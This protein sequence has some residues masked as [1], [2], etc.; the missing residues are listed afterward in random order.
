MAELIGAICLYQA[1]GQAAG[2]AWSSW[3]GDMVP[4]ATRGTWFSRR[5]R[6]VY[7]AT[8]VGL[9]TGGLL[10][11][12]LAP[13]GTGAAGSAG[14]FALLL[15]IAAVARAVSGL[16]L[17]AAP[18]PNFSGLL[19]RRRAW[20]AAGTRRG[21]TA[22]R[23]LGLAAVFHFTVYW[24]SPYFSPFMLTDLGFTYLQYMA[25]ALSV[26]VVKAVVGPTWGLAADRSGPRRV[27]L[28]SMFVIAIVPL[29]WV[30]AHGIPLVVLGQVLSGAA[31]SGFEVGY[32]T[33]IL[34]NSRSRERPYLFALQSLGNGWMQLS[35]VMV[36]SLVILPLVGGYREVFAV[37]AVGRMLV[38]L[39]APFVLAGLVSGRRALREAV[40]LRVFGLRAHGGFAVRPVLGPET[41]G[42]ADADESDG[43]DAPAPDPMI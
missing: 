4:A 20:Q 30:W 8:C 38:V 37:S 33:L 6:L 16:L 34:E 31:W 22:L 23:I 19:P 3:Y 29:P 26:I 11:H 13:G 7:A 28:G 2:T 14:A 25:V 10:M 32:L 21:G 40:T 24:A 12:R 5:N 35:G 36:A 42:D 1:A 9:V 17:A 15:G 18:E 27:F 41:D 39:A 43:D